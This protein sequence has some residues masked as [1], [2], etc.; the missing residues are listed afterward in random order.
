MNGAFQ[1]LIIT[2][3][4]LYQDQGFDFRVVQAALEE[5]GFSIV[6]WGPTVP[7]VEVLRT[8][9]AKSCQLWLISDSV[10]KLSAEH[11]EEIRQ[12]YC[13]RRGVF[14]W[15]DN[16][17]YYADINSCCRV[18]GIKCHLEGNDHGGQ[19]LQE[20]KSV[21]PGFR[22]HLITTGLENLFEGITISTIIPDEGQAGSSTVTGLVWS[23]V[24]KLVTGIVDEDRC[25]CIV[26]GG[27]T[28]LY[29]N[30]DTAGTAR[31]VKNAAGWL[32]NC[33]VHWRE[34]D[35]LQKGAK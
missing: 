30:W 9:L 17:P 7:S 10:A 2:V 28:R 21:G 25:R 15:G 31:F 6:R 20:R 16:D 32:V 18:L 8:Q 5:K 11:L 34:I 19:V 29:C 14:L 27:F 33:E 22:Q 3:L 13:N 4:H 24:G 1:G 26:D 35:A 12:F 23:S